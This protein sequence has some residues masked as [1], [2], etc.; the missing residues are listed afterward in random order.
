MKLK[1]LVVAGDGIGPEVT[2]E[3]IK[4]LQSVAEVGGHD[5]H[6]GHRL[7]LVADGARRGCLAGG[8]ELASGQSALAAGGERHDLR[9]A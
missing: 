3:A 4:I 6:H 7:E 2:R 9:S 1:I 5:Q 8:G